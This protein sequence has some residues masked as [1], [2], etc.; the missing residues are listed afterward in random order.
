MQSA[1]FNSLTNAILTIKNM[2][3][4]IFVVFGSLYLAGEVYKINR[5]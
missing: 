3:K 5:N 1:E 4:T 2:E